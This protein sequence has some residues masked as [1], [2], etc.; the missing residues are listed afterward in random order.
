VLTTHT[1]VPAGN[2]TYDPGELLDVLGPIADLTGDRDAFLARGRVYPADHG[3]QPGLSAFALRTSRSANGVSRL[4]GEVARSMWQPL[5]AAPT[6]DQTPITHVTNGVH[7]PTWLIGP[8]RQL[9]DEHLGDGWIDRAAD[10][11]TWDPVADIPDGQVWAARCAARE[12]FVRWLRQRATAD[13]LR[14]GEHIAYA[15]AAERGFSPDCLTLGFARRLAAYKRLY[16]LS[17]RPERSLALLDGERSVQLA[18]AG[19][20]HPLDDGAK[21]IVR[22]L[23]RLKGEG[24]VGNSVAFIEDYDLAV[25]PE[26]VAGC[27]VWINVPRPPQEASG[28]SGMKSALNGGLNLSVLDG[29]WAEAYDGTNGW[30]IDGRIGDSDDAQD[31]Y[32]ADALFDLLEQ[33]VVPLF[34]D[35]GDDGVPRGWVAMVKASLRTNGP[36]F[37][38]GRMVAEY[39]DRIYPG[40]EGR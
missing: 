24:P 30:A 11:A 19:K 14:R 39:A 8:M 38:A 26:L 5:F 25:A 9:L 12:R 20:A 6:P 16:L 7:V 1:P 32:H 35:R 40:G 34:H 15:Q 17:M 33:Q 27:D 22:D 29:W 21:A 18:I 13:R 4:H 28:T 37:S 31:Q 23:F 3:Q 2:E 36:R 10:P